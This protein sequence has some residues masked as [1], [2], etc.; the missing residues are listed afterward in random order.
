MNGLTTI[1]ALGAQSSFIEQFNKYQDLHSSGHFLYLSITRAFGYWL[2]CCC[3]VYLAIITFSIILFQDSN[4]GQVGLSLTQ[5]MA[6]TG[7]V[8]WGMRRSAELE[9]LMIAVNRITEYAELKEEDDYCLQD[10]ALRRKSP[11]KSWPEQGTIIFNGLS[12]RYSPDPNSECVLKSLSLD[13]RSFEKIGIVGRTGAGKSSLINA[14]FRL[15]YCE[16]T[17]LI[18]NWNTKDIKL[19]DLR[20]KISI[21]P[22]EPVLFS[23]TLRF[24]LDPFQEYSDIKLWEVLDEVRLQ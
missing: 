14:L 8:Q 19:S 9:N 17:I 2:D 20:K 6:L 1:R 13:I 16:G 7:M 18:D 15:S 3:I 5:A 24:N 11:P 10:T 12:L 23:G 21:I 4:G 22:Q